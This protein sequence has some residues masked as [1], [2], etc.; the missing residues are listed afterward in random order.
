MVATEETSTSALVVA[1]MKSRLDKVCYRRFR[2]GASSTVE[3]KVQ[4]QRHPSRALHYLP[5][6]P[7]I[8]KS[9]ANASVDIR[10]T[11][12]ESGGIWSWPSSLV[13]TYRELPTLFS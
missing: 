13:C 8:R 11:D 7:G 9:V 5:I 1:A 3:R 6:L 4:A 10:L 2:S 12:A